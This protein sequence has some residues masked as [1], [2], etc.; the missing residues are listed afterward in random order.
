M[1]ANSVHVVGQ[2]RA[3]SV[4]QACAMMNFFLSAE[5]LRWQRHRASTGVH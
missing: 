1:R 4:K 3:P 5:G 2:R